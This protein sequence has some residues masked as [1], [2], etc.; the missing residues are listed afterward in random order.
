MIYELKH[1]SAE[2]WEDKL[3]IVKSH[4][5]NGEKVGCV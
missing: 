4:M 5:D 2:A 1:E 3:D